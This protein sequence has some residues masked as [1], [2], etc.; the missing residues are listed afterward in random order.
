[1]E[2]A[3]GAECGLVH[4]GAIHHRDHLDVAAIGLLTQAQQRGLN[5][6]ALA[7]AGN[8][9][10]DLGSV[11]TDLR[12]TGTPT[13]EPTQYAQQHDDDHGQFEQDERWKKHVEQ[14]AQSIRPCE[15]AECTQEL[16]QEW[17]HAVSPSSPAIRASNS[18]PSS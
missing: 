8:D 4:R 18:S 5:V 1:M 3:N 13:G 9:A 15:R 2:I 7:V 17:A 11:N 14:A 6:H 16:L 10:R 12:N